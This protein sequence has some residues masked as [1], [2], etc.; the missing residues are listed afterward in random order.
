[1]TEYNEEES[2]RHA[3]EINMNEKLPRRD[4]GRGAWTLLT[5]VSFILTMTWGKRDPFNSIEHDLKLTVDL[6]RLW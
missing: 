1:M 5:A 6:N 4:G 3:Q 2:S